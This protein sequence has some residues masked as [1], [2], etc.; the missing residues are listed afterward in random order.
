MGIPG[1]G[2]ALLSCLQLRKEGQPLNPESMSRLPIGES[3]KGF[4]YYR[5][6]ANIPRI[7]GNEGLSPEGSG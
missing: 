3:Q 6:A 4:R 1:T 2:M 5:L 7:W